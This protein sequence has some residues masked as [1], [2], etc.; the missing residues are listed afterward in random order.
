MENL[1]SL[2]RIL[3]SLIENETTLKK[4]L[5]CGFGE[6]MGGVRVGAPEP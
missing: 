1:Q 3:D 4:E 6:K 5:Y 2:K